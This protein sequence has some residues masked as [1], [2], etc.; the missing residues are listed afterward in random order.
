MEAIRQ[1]LTFIL[2]RSLQSCQASRGAPSIEEVTAS[3]AEAVARG[4]VLVLVVGVVVVAPRSSEASESRFGLVVLS[5]VCPDFFL[6]NAQG[7]DQNAGKNA[8]A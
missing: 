4:N 5:T 3:G 2:Y 6:E 8:P 7:I 1:P